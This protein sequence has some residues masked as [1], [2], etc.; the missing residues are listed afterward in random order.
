MR[1]K[2]Y[3]EDKVEDRLEPGVDLDQH[4][5]YEKKGRR[6]HRRGENGPNATRHYFGGENPTAW[7][8]L[9][10]GP[11]MPIRKGQGGKQQM[12]AFGNSVLISQNFPADPPTNFDIGKSRLAR[13]SRRSAHR[14][15]W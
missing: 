7:S 11:S 14:F 5:K 6:T 10:T 4:N 9:G 13:A 2:K 1:E 15:P 8:L 12:D 3:G